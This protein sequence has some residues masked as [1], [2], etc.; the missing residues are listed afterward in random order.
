M[1][2]VLDLVVKDRDAQEDIDHELN[3]YNST[4][5]ATK[6]ELDK[7]YCH[8]AKTYEHAINI[9]GDVIYNKLWK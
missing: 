3:E 5:E 8:R 9:M 7:I 2:K 1:K 4:S 6:L